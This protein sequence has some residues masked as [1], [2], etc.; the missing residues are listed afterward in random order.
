MN[1]RT[2]LMTSDM[3]NADLLKQINEK[4]DRILKHFGIGD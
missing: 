4:L 2:G 3:R 1:F